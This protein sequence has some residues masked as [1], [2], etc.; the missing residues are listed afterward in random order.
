MPLVGSASAFNIAK[1]LGQKPT[2]LWIILETNLETSCM[3]LSNYEF[4]PI[5]KN[6]HLFHEQNNSKNLNIY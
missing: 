1:V 5:I 2:E 3:Q 4:V 6:N